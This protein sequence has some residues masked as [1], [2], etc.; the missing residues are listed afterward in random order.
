MNYHALKCAMHD[1]KFDEFV[2]LLHKINRFSPGEDDILCHAAFFGKAKYVR[3][4]IQSGKL[5]NMLECCKHAILVCL[6]RRTFNVLDVI[7][8]HLIIGTLKSIR[9]SQQ[10]KMIQDCLLIFFG[11]HSSSH[12]DFVDIKNI[13]NRDR[14]KSLE[15]CYEN[16]IKYMDH[17]CVFRSTFYDFINHF[18]IKL[19][20]FLNCRDK[21]IYLLLEIVMSH[22]IAKE[23]TDYEILKMIEE[24]N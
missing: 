2:I 17:K 15:Y 7:L 24:H 13:S 22:P 5:F 4:L 1:D 18:I 12:S 23:F 6:K 20:S 3:V 10:V 9:N 21:N 19:L 11:L 14:L 16:I 8:N